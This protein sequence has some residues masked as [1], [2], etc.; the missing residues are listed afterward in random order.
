MAIAMQERMRELQS[1]WRDAGLER[2]FQLKIGISSGYCTVG[3]FGS[4]DRM[5]YTI[6]GTEVNL[7][8]RLQQH[9]EPGT[10]LVS[11]ETW[12]LIKEMV[13]AEEQIPIQAKGFA[14]PV[15]NYKVLGSM[16]NVD[17]Q[18]G[19][20]RQE[21]DGMK[22]VLDLRKVD[23]AAAIENLREILLQL[24]GETNDGALKVHPSRESSLS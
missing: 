16:D 18:A 9:A 8:S 4:E 1:E 21:A 5:D 15:R 24:G 20:I 10:I 6:I 11:H 22:I 17:G 19:V 23:R 13:V 14:K 3:N 12:A 2:P 7:A